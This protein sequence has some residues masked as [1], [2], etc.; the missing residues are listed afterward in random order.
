MDLLSLIETN[1][2]SSIWFWI[3]VAISWSS[4]SH[5]ILGVP[6][7]LVQ[8]A[9]KVGGVAEERIH[10]LLRI[11]ASRLENIQRIAGFVLTGIVSFFL[12]G[13]AIL[14][15]VYWIEF[16]QALF[17]LTFPWVFVGTIT[18]NTVRNLDEELPTGED[19]YKMFWRLRLAIQGIGLVSIFITSIWGMYSIIR[20]S[21]FPA[22]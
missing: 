10:T 15:F 6:F 19:L 1:S 20:V 11:N 3:L 7:D 8:R 9:R 21:S 12:T 14:G 22:M 18:V 2:F 5:W 16:F 13:F 17:L 4:G